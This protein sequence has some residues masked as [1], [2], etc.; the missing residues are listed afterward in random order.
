MGVSEVWVGSHEFSCE[1][2]LRCKFE[3]Y[4]SFTVDYFSSTK[5]GE[6]LCRFF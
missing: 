5:G 3:G 6:L 1:S 4:L 2:Q